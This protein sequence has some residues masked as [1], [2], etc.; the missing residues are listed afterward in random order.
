MQIINPSNAVNAKVSSKY[1]K[2]LKSK[3]YEAMSKL[4]SVSEVVIYLR[5]NT[6][7]KNYL[8]K[9]N[10]SK[11]TRSELETLLRK[12]LFLDLM[13]LCKYELASN[14]AIKHYIIR[15]FE[16]KEIIS[17]LSLLKLGEEE[18]YYESVPTYLQSFSGV[19]IKRMSLS[20]NYSETL[21]SLKDTVYYDILIKYKNLDIDEINLSKVEDELDRFNIKRLF[22]RLKKKK[23]KIKEVENFYNNINAYTN[24][25]R[26]MRLK[27][28]YNLPPE[29]IYPHLR[30]SGALGDLT[31]KRMCESE[32]TEDVKKIFLNTS[33]GKQVKN[34]N[35]D[36][37]DVFLQ[38]ATFNFT[39]HNMHFC[40]HTQVVLLNYLYISEIELANVIHMIEGARYHLPIE[41]I[42]PLIIFKDTAH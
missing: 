19:N 40:S 21:S 25:H 28:Y 1:G 31:I 15:R 24:F 29:E 33:I 10:E 8:D 39:E 23:I 14:N 17:F 3:D 6:H 5:N 26:I 16:I 22:F 35:I 7:Y 41:D 11:I 9:I 32:S 2:I 42:K 30:H 20:R 12:E 18:K 13:R 37:Y 4:S 34:L 36:T 27:Q 38:Q